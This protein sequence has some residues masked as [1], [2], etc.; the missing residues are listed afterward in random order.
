MP[1]PP[2]D[3]PDGSNGLLA[4]MD[5]ARSSTM[6]RKCDERMSLSL[7]Y[8]GYLKISV[9]LVSSASTSHTNILMTS[10]TE[11]PEGLVVYAQKSRHEYTARNWITTAINF[12]GTARTQ[13]VYRR[14]PCYKTRAKGF[15]IAKNCPLL[16]GTAALHNR[17]TDR[18][19]SS[20]YTTSRAQVERRTG[21]LDCNVRLSTIHRRS[22]QYHSISAILEIHISRCVWLCWVS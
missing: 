4:N 3:A 6:L 18:R 10:A 2:T 11:F 14:K 7:S 12:H 13:D 22:S 17:G 16:S 15:K 8:S 5:A 9:N 20:M 1:Q 19:R 21:N